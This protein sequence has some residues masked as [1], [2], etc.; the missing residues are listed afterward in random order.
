MAAAAGPSD[1]ELLIETDGDNLGASHIVT[2]QNAAHEIPVPSLRLHRILD[3]AG[4]K[5]VHMR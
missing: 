4:L 1:G 3:D 5:H 2:S